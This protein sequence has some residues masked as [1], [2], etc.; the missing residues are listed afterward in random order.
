VFTFIIIRVKIKGVVDFDFKKVQ[1]LL[2]HI[3]VSVTLLIMAPR[4]P[5]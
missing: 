4:P 2:F 3:P 5:V 1:P